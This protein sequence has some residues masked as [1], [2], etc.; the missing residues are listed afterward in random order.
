M[1]LWYKKGG[2][3]V[4]VSFIYEDVM[5]LKSVFFFIFL[6]LWVA[7]IIDAGTAKV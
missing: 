1:A 3:A 6:F 2:F 7:F 5:G 4:L